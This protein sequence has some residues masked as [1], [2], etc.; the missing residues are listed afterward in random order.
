MPALGRLSRGR[1]CGARP[2]ARREKPAGSIVLLT[3]G[4]GDVLSPEARRGVPVKATKTAQA[5]PLKASRFTTPKESAGFLLWQ[6]SNAWHRRIRKELEAVD[7]THVQFV[8]L[9]GIAWLNRTQSDVTQVDLARHTKI[10]VMTTSQVLRVLESRG[11]VLRKPH[12]HD[13]RA[14]C[15][16]LASESEALL[17]RAIKLVENADESFFAPLGSDL[18]QFSHAM[19]LLIETSET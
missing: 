5:M 13:A 12:K 7:L 10:D 3:S 6:L 15:M 18:D 16:V 14:K 1:A 4:S 2:T 8:L 19:K 9:A 17:K 11:L